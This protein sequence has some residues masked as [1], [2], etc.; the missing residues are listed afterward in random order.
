MKPL[1]SLRARVLVGAIFWTAGLV[2]LASAVLA[3]GI[4]AHPEARL[5]V[6]RWLESPYAL[7]IGLLCIAAG[8]LQV[9]GGLAGLDRVGRS[10][11]ALHRGDARRL[12]GAFPSEVQPLVEDLNALL[13]QR[14]RAVERALA[15]AGDLAHGIKTPLAVL[16]HEAD[17]LA[18]PDAAGAMASIRQQIDAMRRQLDY[19]LAQSRAAV[20]RTS[21][22]RCRV[23]DSVE[24]L[25]RALTR[26]HA[27]RALAIDVTGADVWIGGRHED[28]DE[29]L[30]NVLDNACRFARAR[31]AL[32]VTAAGNIVT[33]S[34]DDDGP[35]IPA[36]LR[37]AALQRG[38]RADQSGT[39][40]GL[41]LAI[42]RDVAELY[43]GSIALGDSPLGGL[44]VTVR[45]P[46]VP[47]EVAPRIG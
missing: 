15:R 20:G 43:G 21:S 24:G 4:S 34:I 3:H 28:L 37:A 12:E 41:G 13:D 19:H 5:D 17:R 33:V 40:W 23:R 36:A 47:P 8:F 14:D 46:S 18:S 7:V 35:G 2:A 32:H 16:A 42:A 31:V 45:L 1:L 9:R 22:E 26:L 25:V 30:G 29:M 6:H 44:R 27:E 10:L 38:T 39:G 11:S